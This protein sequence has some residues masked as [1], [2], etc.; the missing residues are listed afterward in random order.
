M[1]TLCQVCYVAYYNPC[2]Q[3][4]AYSVES[5]SE[6]KPVSLSTVPQ[7]RMHAIS[8][9]RA[10]AREDNHLA[11]YEIFDPSQLNLT[12]ENKFRFTRALIHLDLKPYYQLSELETMI[13]PSTKDESLWAICHRPIEGCPEPPRE[14][15]RS[16]RKGCRTTF[17]AKTI[18]SAAC[19][20]FLGA[21]SLT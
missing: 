21:L 19:R 1:S 3:C 2:L 16:R 18:V 6:G 11:F 12:E 15:E 7:G 8:T 17:K 13:H 14:A 10:F 9:N 5:T 4:G 20:S